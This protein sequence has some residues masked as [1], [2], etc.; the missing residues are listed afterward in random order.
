MLGR[1]ALAALLTA[2]GVAPVK[3]AV[4][5]NVIMAGHSQRVTCT[6]PRDDRNRWITAGIVGYTSSGRSLNG[7]EAYVTTAVLFQ[8]VPCGSELA[9]CELETNTGEHIIVNAK[10]M[11]AGCEEGN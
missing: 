4:S 2:A 10:F 5:S 3:V 1:V 9:F 7:S 8:K 11:V 6:V